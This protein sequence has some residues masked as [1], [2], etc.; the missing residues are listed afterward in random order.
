[1][2]PPPRGKIPMALAALILSAYC[3]FSWAV[4]LLPQTT[5]ACP[6]CTV[7]TK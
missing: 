1:M 4:L 7:K 3:T 2:S 5:P 6:C